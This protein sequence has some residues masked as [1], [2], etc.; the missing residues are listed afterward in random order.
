MKILINKVLKLSTVG[1]VVLL[2]PR[3]KLGVLENI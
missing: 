1:Y 2:Y 3:L